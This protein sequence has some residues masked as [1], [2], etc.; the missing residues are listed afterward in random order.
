MPFTSHVSE[1]PTST[2]SALALAEL[3]IGGSLNGCEGC[4]RWLAGAI[5]QALDSIQGEFEGRRMHSAFAR[6]PAGA[7]R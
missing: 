1:W 4:P 3:V 5:S 6:R 2:A 7:G